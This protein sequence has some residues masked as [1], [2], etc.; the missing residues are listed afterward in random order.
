MTP[1]TMTF[2][3]KQLQTLP[4]RASPAALLISVNPH[5]SI[6]I[7]LKL[8]PNGTISFENQKQLLEYKNNLLIS[9]T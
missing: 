2:G 6:T 9:D 5:F 1:L 4:L 3:L 8:S 7:C